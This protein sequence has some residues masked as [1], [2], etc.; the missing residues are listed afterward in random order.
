VTR[1][2]FAS[3]SGLL[4]GAERVLL[5]CAS[6]V[7]GSHTLICPPGPLAQQARAAGVTVLV[8]PERELRLRSNLRTRAGAARALAAHAT[9]LRRLVR[10]LDP[11]LTVAWGMRS[12]LA[13]LALPGRRAVA[14]DHHD[15]LPGPVIAAGVRAAAHRAAVVTVPSAAVGAELDPSGRLS[16]RLRVVAPG[17]D[18]MRFAGLG[19][20]AAAPA[21]LVLGALAP[22]KRP[23]LALEICA[24]ARERLPDLTV[25]L[26]GGPVTSD[27]SLL[28]ELE[29]RV[30][31]GDLAGAAELA[32][33]QDETADELARAAC[34]LHCAPREPFG[35]VLLEA[36]A[37]G[38]PVVA[39]DAGGPR[40]ILDSS[41]A[42]LY[43]PGDARAGADALV[44]LLSD[45]ARVRTMGDAGRKRVRACF[46][47]QRT[48]SGFRDALEPVL[49]ACPRPTAAAEATGGAQ[50][51][52]TAEVAVVTVTHNSADEL[53][54]LLASVRRHL[55]GAAITVVDCAS[56]DRSVAV[57]RG[58]PGVKTIALDENIGFGGACNRG[59]DSVTAPVSA[60]LNPDVELIDTSLAGLAAEALRADRPPRLLAPLILSAD[61]SRQQTVHPRP[62]SGPDLVR[63]VIPPG[64]IPGAAGA[65]LAPWRATA[66]RPV[67]WAVAAALVASTATLR[68]L[69]PFDESIFMYGEDLELALR[70]AAQGIETWFWPGVRVLH[71]GAHATGP[72]FGGEA[73]ERL[74]RARH[75]VVTRSLG[76]RRGQL[77][78]AVQALTFASRWVYKRALGR[79]ADREQRQLAALDEV[80]HTP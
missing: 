61:G 46:D 66:P 42:I 44:T 74:A 22:W 49:A 25:R 11:E 57:A 21:V 40:E 72:A 77:D 69:G 41:C 50:V 9:E 45:R 34:L 28:A 14:F 62:L 60:L 48:R 17:V 16:A 53:P 27:E 18:P 6:G 4:G 71:G 5:D 59:L 13:S 52:E 63:A 3:Y 8:G 37:A 43:P 47:R 65:W 56:G 12:A 70:A 68:Q 15:F 67:G 80:R 19:P 79:A 76:K 2:L 30:G 23:D 58:T 33:P 55:P 26:V 29:R 64:A 7:E 10:D 32:G 35:I 73:F 75:E 54:S 24:L 31:A 38:R 39:P 78:D 36:M 1:I 20:P 51:A